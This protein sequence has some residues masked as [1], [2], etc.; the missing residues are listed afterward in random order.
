MAKRKCETE[1]GYRA[2]EE[3]IRLFR[4]QKEGNMALGSSHNMIYDWSQGITPSA[5]FLARMHELGADVIW[6]LTG[7]KSTSPMGNAHKN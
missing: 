5:M 7:K 6:I 2:A 3:C 4:T 1:I